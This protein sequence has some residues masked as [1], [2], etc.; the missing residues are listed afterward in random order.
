MFTIG[1]KVVYPMYGAG[2]IEEIEEKLIDGIKCSY[3]VLRICVGDLKIS[4]SPNNVERLGIRFVMSPEEV[5]DIV[6]NTKTI[7]MS[8]NWNQRYKDN[9]VRIKTGEL[10]QVVA[11]YKT[12]VLRERTRPLSSV[13]KKMLCNVK[14]IILSEIILTQNITKAQAE[15]VLSESVRVI[16]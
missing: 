12:L 7:A 4:I 14:Q 3:Y 5:M 11:V 15:R 1:D 13:E 6:N 8:E 2:T 10:A 16:A 9:T